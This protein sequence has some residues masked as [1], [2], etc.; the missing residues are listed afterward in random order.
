M[1]LQ[2]QLLGLRHR[3]SQRS[4]SLADRRLGMGIWRC[5]L[6]CSFAT[7]DAVDWGD[8]ASAPASVA[9]SIAASVS[10]VQGDTPSDTTGMSMHMNHMNHSTLSALP[11]S[12]HS[13]LRWPRDSVEDAA[14]IVTATSSAEG[15]CLVTAAEERDSVSVMLGTV[16]LTSQA[17]LDVGSSCSS[18]IT[19]QHPVDSGGEQRQHEIEGVSSAVSRSEPEPVFEGS[20]MKLTGRLVRHWRPRTLRVEVRAPRMHFPILLPLAVQCGVVSLVSGF[21]VVDARGANAVG[22]AP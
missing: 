5:G 11:P 2:R 22:S 3:R 7:V 8:D 9:A 10:L 17:P 18:R 21:V 14:S 20:L 15:G 12:P 6:A 1:L 19:Q 4:T 13:H 16:G